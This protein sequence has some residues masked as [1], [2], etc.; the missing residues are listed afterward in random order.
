MSYSVIDGLVCRP[1]SIFASLFL[2]VEHVFLLAGIIDVAIV[3][4]IREDQ[5]MRCLEDKP[6]MSRLVM[7]CENL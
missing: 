5:L 1:I 3:Q 7:Y 4:V 6:H 2:M